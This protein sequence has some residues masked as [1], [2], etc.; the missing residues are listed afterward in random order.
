MVGGDA[1]SLQVRT[2]PDGVDEA[3]MESWEML[4]RRWNTV[5]QVHHNQLFGSS[6]HVAS[7]GSTVQL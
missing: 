2:A 7:I 6:W 1:D 5:F 4:P 3:P